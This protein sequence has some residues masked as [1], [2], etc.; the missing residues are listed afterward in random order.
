MKQLAIIKNNFLKIED[1]YSPNATKSS[2]AVRFHP[3]DDDIRDPFFRDVDRIITG[4]SIMKKNEN[5][6]NGR[7][8]PLIGI[9]YTAM[10]QKKGFPFIF[11]WC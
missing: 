8:N 7:E 9:M 4:I 10:C 1:T 11:C 5:S 6:M 2:E 3:I